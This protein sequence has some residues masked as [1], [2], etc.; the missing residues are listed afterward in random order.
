M[1]P[2]LACAASLSYFALLLTSDLQRPEPLGMQI[3]F[4]AGGLRVARVDAGSPA[5]RAGVRTGDRITRIG[6]ITV[7]RRIDALAADTHLTA[8]RP[9]TLALDRNGLPAT[10][11]LVA[12]PAT[13]RY[14]THRQGAAL[15]TV[16]AVQLV[17]LLLACVLLIRRPYDRHARLGAWLLATV[18]VFSV[19]LP[20]G[21]GESWRALP[22]LVGAILFV[23][24]VLSVAIA[25]V[26]F[27]FFAA[28]PRPLI[29]GVVRWAAVW[30]PMI[31]V[32]SWHAVYGWHLIYAPEHV[33]LMPDWSLAVVAVSLAYGIALVAAIVTSYR[34][35][36]DVNDR[37]RLKVLLAGSLIGCVAGGP[38]AV[39]YWA[40]P[41]K[42]TAAPLFAS[43]LASI[44]AL[45]FLAL[46]LSFAY[47]VLR[48][49]LFDV[50]LIVRRG[51]QYALA[52]RVLVSVVPALAVLLV[53]DLL[54]HGDRPLIDTLETRGAVY[55]LIGVVAVVAHARSE[56][57][58]DALDR[59]FFRERYNAQRILR[60]IVEDIRTG[61]GIE[62]IAARV[63]R[64]IHTALH[65]TFVAMLRRRRGGAAF[66]PIAVT[67]G[68]HSVEPLDVNTR[69]VALVGVLRRPTDV[70]RTQS[71]WIHR[72]LP[73]TEGAYLSRNAIDLIVPAGPDALLALGPK[74]SE[75]PYSSEDGDL[76]AA[77]GESVALRFVRD[78]RVEEV[79]AR[80]IEECP[81]CGSVYD[82]GTDACARDAVA[83][84]TI[85]IPRVLA[86]RYRL[87]RR[88]G[89]G[90]MGAV[91]SASDA[92]LGR[93][94]AAKVMRDELLSAPD[95]EERFHREARLAA[96]LAHPNVV[97]VYDF[98]VF[99]GRAF[100]VMELLEGATLRDELRVHPRPAPGRVVEILR[101][102]CAAVDAAHDVK[103]V[104]RDLK[105]ENVF[106]SRT[107]RGEV[108]K[109]LDFGVAKTLVAA[110]E[111]TGTA[112][113]NTADGVL[114]GTLPYMAP[115]Q[116]RGEPVTPAA[117]LWSIAVIAHEMVFGYHPFA[118]AARTNRAVSSV[119]AADAGHM[120]SRVFAR[121]LAVEPSDRHSSAAAFLDE[122]ERAIV[123]P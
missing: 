35:L 59:R 93:R 8:G 61:E 44:G 62:A 86:N 103:L 25:A 22:R 33:H 15:L 21:I 102:V 38:V 83:L 107:P 34:S 88:L 17:T 100:L 1:W 65:P 80:S 9:T 92:A 6:E 48:H 47:A 101:G 2:A 85:A 110:A 31:A 52:R 18:G 122:L 72:E 49:R 56:E 39:L 105:P 115:E 106:L 76:L 116:L 91:Y 70:S 78:D 121:A 58:L 57:W 118:T 113:I 79:A 82:S 55:A 99:A 14:W 87:E 108:V 112:N 95:A 53:I 13:W 96:S 10:A 19:T 109:V 27:T 117:D 32:L 43:P 24:Y 46:P 119:S 69:L 71:A 66:E 94:V 50:S 16:R 20:Y 104:H 4:D 40:G 111:W 120:A 37:R 81:Q 12:N 67:P 123:R 5:D 73:D 45:A 63:V 74:Q 23:P 77:V 7:R 68:Q 11:T 30:T 64:Q 90:G 28:F 97:T 36:T 42:G 54:L 3:E 84:K 89:H 29:R 98:G 41:G 75:E 114:L 60:E 26:A 51:L